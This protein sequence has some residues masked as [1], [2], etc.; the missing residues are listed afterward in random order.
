MSP[1]TADPIAMPQRMV[2]VTLTIPAR[3]AK[4]L[5]ARSPLVRSR[6]GSNV[7]AYVWT[8]ETNK[9][10][11]TARADVDCYG[12][13]RGFRTAPFE[14]LMEGFEW[15]GLQRFGEAIARK[16]E[17]IIRAALY[18]RMQDI[19]AADRRAP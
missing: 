2:K 19:Q 7:A 17:K 11:D 13:L 12:D 9:P 8:A 10:V 18:R 1:L 6:Y 16:P 15:E 3:I 4:F 14:I 5:S